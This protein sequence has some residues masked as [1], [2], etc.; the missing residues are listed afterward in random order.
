MFL[1]VSLAETQDLVVDQFESYSNDFELMENWPFSKAG[2]ED[3]LFIFLDKTNHPPEG[4]FCL[5][6]DVDMPAKWWYN[7]IQ[8]NLDNSPLDLSQYR[9]VSFWIYG[10]DSLNA[11]DLAVVCFLYDSQNRVLRFPLPNEYVVNASWQKVTLAIDSFVD[12]QWD[13]GY[14]TANPD[15]VRDDIVKLGL[16]CVGNVDNIFATLFVDDIRIIGS[17]QSSTVQGTIVEGETAMASVMVHAIG[18]NSVEITKTD[19][20][21]HYIFSELIQ[22]R[23]YRILP[24]EN[25]YDFNPGVVSQTLLNAEYTFDFVGAPSIYN[26]L[27][28]TTIRDAFDE[29]GLNPEI[30]YRGVAQWNNPGDDR[31]VIEVT[32]DKTYIVGFPDAQQ[33]DAFMP[34]IEPNALAG[35]SSPRFAVEI[36]LSY[37]WDMLVFGQNTN[38]N[39]YAEVDA[40]CEIRDDLAAGYDRI[41]L[42]IRCNASNPSSPVLDGAGDTVPYMSSGGYALSYETDTAQI[43]ARKYGNSNDTA[44][45]LHRLEGYAADF[46]SVA[47]NESGWHRFRIECQ[48]ETITFLV[49][50]NL[51][52]SVT[53]PEYS[54]GPAGLHYRACFADNPF[55]LQNIHHAR[56]DNLLAGPTRVVCVE[57]WMVQ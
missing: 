39:Y 5:E 53:D 43:V 18:H 37:A 1:F 41:S 49:D 16:M 46:A 6:L 26:D 54:R 20:N 32:Q 45:A 4:S 33:V 22:G 56:F 8:R 30:V 9:S 34:G 31:P 23:T 24:Q 48:D 42:G 47:I 19:E 21:G 50:G 35:A 14:G 28:T 25:G 44:H 10:D 38:R 51:L 29:G 52:I 12:E 55:D 2:G 15:A 57:N 36:G 7:I 3:G 11:G 40:Y 17:S 27:E 13:A